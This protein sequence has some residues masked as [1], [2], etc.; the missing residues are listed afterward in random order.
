MQLKILCAFFFLACTGYAQKIIPRFEQLSVNDGLSH[1]S[2]YSIMQ[3][4]KGFM[5]FGTADGLCR[6]DGG[7]LTPFRYE[8]ANSEDVVN[9]FVRGKILEDNTGNIWYSNESGIYKWDAVREKIIKIVAFNKSYGNVAFKCLALDA[10][11]TLWLFNMQEGIFEFNISAGTFKQYPLPA[12]AKVSN[13]LFS[14]QTIDTAGNFWIRLLSKNDPFFVFNKSLHQYSMRLADDPP[15]AIFFSKENEVHAFLDRIVYKDPQTGLSH[16]VMKQIDNKPV[17]FYSFDAVRDH[18]GRLWMTARGSGLFYYDEK[19]DRFQEYHHDNSKIKSL[20]FDLT[21]CLYIDRSQ[22]LWIGIDGGGV[23][24]LDLK[25]PRFNLFPLSEGDYPVLNDYFT[26]CFYEDEKG[27]TWFGSQTNGLNI[28]DRESGKLVNYQYKNNSSTSLPGNIV[29]SILKDRDGNMWIGS[30]GGI[31]LFDEKHGVFKTVVLHGLPKLYPAI[32]VFVY[33]M[34]QLQNGEL[35]AATAS[36][37]VKI[38]KQPDGNYEGYYF[39]D[40]PFLTSTAT[41]IVEMDN[42]CIYIT[43]PNFGLYELKPEAGRYRVSNIF[44]K[45]IDLRSARPDEQ[46]RHWLWVGTGKGL[47]HFNT[48]TQQQQLW[49]ETSG[50]ANA[51]IYGSLEDS[52]GNLWI[53]TNGGLSYFNRTKQHFEN[54]TYQDGLQSNEFN[55]QS[56]YKSASGIFYFGGI[57]GFNWFRPGPVNS[58]RTKPQA[59][60]IKIY[61]RD[62]TF[63]KDSAFI[64]DRT[65]TVPY[66]EDEFSFQFAALDYTRPEA[67]KMQYTL[68]GWDDDW[69]NTKS[70]AVR[71]SNLLPGKY[72]FRLKVSN[73]EGVWSDEEQVHIFIRAPFWKRTWFIVIMSLLALFIVVIITYGFFELKARKKMRLLEKQI[74]IDTERNRISADMHDE[75][76]SGITHIALLSELIQQQEKD[77]TGIK[78]DVNIIALSARKLVQ[79]MGEIIW[80]LNPQNETLEN[81]LAYIREQSQ[82]YFEN[83]NVNFSIDFPDQV[84][85]IKLTNEQRRNLFLVTKEALSNAMKHAQAD[86]IHLSLAIQGNQYCFIVKDNGNG[87]PANSTKLGS[88]G[89]RNMKKRML[90]IGGTIEWSNDEGTK[91]EYCWKLI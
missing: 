91:V 74:A 45:G 10:D 65:I 4:K 81:L 43:I 6:Y 47:V 19:Q 35:V 17:S 44:L 72:T 39:N 78:K 12:E 82:Q 71:Y 1:S 68:E 20:S 61:I 24:K 41:D 63:Q 21:T 2:V 69:I 57:K 46:D 85:D 64:N 59:A 55:T 83:M 70:A 15:H 53:S 13:V 31:S 56:F 33:K 30:S 29:G 49:N 51:Y 14:Y 88:N 75:I 52:V 89:L 86:H 38:I 11:G 16:T 60:I 28:L 79:T 23:A 37:I 32:K 40:D 7:S 87:M 54:Y 77:T 76:G 27:R 66:S 18:S 84:R 80:A 58:I 25:Q 48:E 22:N 9:N 5:W 50:L 62:K 90:D 26:K 3:D 42:L 73:A 34:I 8:P 36:G 67:N